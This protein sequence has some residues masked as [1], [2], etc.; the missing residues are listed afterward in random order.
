VLPWLTFFGFSFSPLQLMGQNGYWVLVV[1]VAVVVIALA[2]AKLTSPGLESSRQLWAWLWVTFG[3]AVVVAAFLLVSFASASSQG[4][5]TGVVA[6]SAGIGLGYLLYAVCAIGGL[7]VAFRAW[8][9]TDVKLALSTPSG[10]PPTHGGSAGSGLTP[11]DRP[12]DERGVQPRSTTSAWVVGVG[13]AVVVAAAAAYFFLQSNSPSDTM[14]LVNTACTQANTWQQD[15][16]ANSAQAASDQSALYGTLQQ[17][18]TKL[19]TLSVSSQA[20]SDLSVLT[21]TVESGLFGPET[22]PGECQD[23][24]Q[25]LQQDLGSSSATP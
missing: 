5:L 18:E 8:R 6:G 25:Q 15:S 12:E 19:Q 10:E 13:V 21:M 22:A 11:P 7:V 9:A 17:L 20:E 4:G 2:V 14:S 3:I 24:Q 16:Q 1:L 23:L